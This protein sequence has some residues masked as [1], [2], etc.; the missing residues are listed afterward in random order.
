M[1]D[2]CESALKEFNI[3]RPKASYPARLLTGHEMG[4]GWW[5]RGR[6]SIFLDPAPFFGHFRGGCGLASELEG[7]ARHPA[8]KIRAKENYCGKAGKRA[9]FR[10]CNG[11]LGI[12]SANTSVLLGQKRLQNMRRMDMRMEPPGLQAHATGEGVASVMV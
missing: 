3:S 1:V 10:V 7:S 6:K 12:Y 2:P 4:V 9:N 5:G 11:Y 8:R